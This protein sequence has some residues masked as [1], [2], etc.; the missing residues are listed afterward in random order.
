MP[1]QVKTSPS[2]SSS[3]KP[4]PSTAKDLRPMNS[5][6]RLTSREMRQDPASRVRQSSAQRPA[7]PGQQPTSQGRRE[8]VREEGLA[9]HRGA[10]RDTKPAWMTKG[11]GIGTTM[12]GEATG[13][14]LKPGLT[15]SRLEEIERQAPDKV[16]HDPF[17]QVFCESSAGRA[18]VENLDRL[19]GDHERTNPSASDKIEESADDCQNTGG[20]DSPLFEHPDLVTCDGTAWAC[21]EIPFLKEANPAGSFSVDF[22]VKPDDGKGY[23]SP[24]TSRDVSPPRGYAFFITN[25]GLWAFWVGLPAANEW[26][27][28]E[29][30]LAKIGQWQRIT[31]TYCPDARSARL[32]V[33]GEKV[34]SATAPIFG[35][36]KVMFEPNGSRPMRLGA[37][38]TED[39]P[40]FAFAGKINGVR[41]YG[42]SLTGSLPE[43][44]SPCN[45]EDEERPAKRQRQ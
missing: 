2:V 37:G 10:Q 28:A 4:R 32:F 13:E 19:D 21:E 43:W 39:R 3:Q 36:K 9:R 29:G 41:I 17:G 33:D 42:C 18:A 14:L 7:T 8:E 44:S 25:K 45:S 26:L 12:F 20:P 6:S 38:A 35:S 30:P 22:W 24:L 5:A 31:G 40:K 1:A 11:L 15:K 23:R 34:A 27:K 16:E